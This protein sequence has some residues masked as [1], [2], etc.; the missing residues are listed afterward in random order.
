MKYFS[1]KKY[2]IINLNADLT[3]CKITHREKNY[4]DMH[5]YIPNKPN[6]QKSKQTLITIKFFKL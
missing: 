4:Y 1:F 2:S 6:L 5:W 3:K